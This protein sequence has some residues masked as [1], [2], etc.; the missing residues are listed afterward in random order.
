MATIEEKYERIKFQNRIRQARYYEKNKIK[1][2][3]ERKIKRNYIKKI[4]SKNKP[5][6]EIPQNRVNLNLK[7]STP[8]TQDIAEKI[9]MELNF[10]NSETPLKDSTRNK[11]RKNIRQFYKLFDGT[12]LRKII[13]KPKLIREIIDSG[14]FQSNTKVDIITGLIKVITHKGVF[15]NMKNKTYEDINAIYEDY[16]AISKQNNKIKITSKTDAVDRIE[17]IVKLIYDKFGKNSK[18]NIILSLFIEA[19][20]RDD[21]HL[22]IV[23]NKNQIIDK[24]NYIIVPKNK[25]KNIQLYIQ[26]HKTSGK[27]DAQYENITKALSAEIRQ[28]IDDKKLNYNDYLFNKKIQ[29]D[30]KRMFLAVNKP[31][32]NGVNQL[33][34]LVISNTLNQPNITL[35][36]ANRLAQTMKHSVKTQASYRRLI[37]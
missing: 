20:K 11:Y 1:I 5:E 32:L 13:D 23:E 2:A 25:S 15:P 7:K 21:F 8:I 30:I 12:D 10:N 34:H 17:N 24:T 4:L 28:Y 19:P 31:K 37:I 35:E 14:N 29:P 22:K 36:E 18:E 16:N 9:C 33:R 27:Y 26:T 6:P 3:E